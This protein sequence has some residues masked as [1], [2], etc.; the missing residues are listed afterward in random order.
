MSDPQVPCPVH[1]YSSSREAL[2]M[3]YLNL[4]QGAAG[5]TSLLS[6]MKEIPRHATRISPPDPPRIKSL[7]VMQARPPDCLR[8]K[9]RKMRAYTVLPLRLRGFFSGNAGKWSPGATR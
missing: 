3:D 6:G 5:R 4:P 1:I 8:T 7:H 2:C 9:N